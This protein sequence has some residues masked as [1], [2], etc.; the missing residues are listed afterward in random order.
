MDP[1]QKGNVSDKQWSQAIAVQD[2]QEA[3]GENLPPLCF[4]CNH[5]TIYEE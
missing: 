5:N 4:P 1:V 2:F 3:H